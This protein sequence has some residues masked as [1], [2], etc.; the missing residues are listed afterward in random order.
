MQVTKRECPFC[1][2]NEK[3]I[4]LT[5]EAHSFC[6]PNFAYIDDPY[7][8][9]N[10]TR[11]TR[12]PFVKCRNCG[13]MFSE[14]LL[15]DDS[16]NKVYEEIINPATCKDYS[17]SETVFENYRKD[18]DHAMGIFTDKTM[19][20]RALDFGAGWGTWAMIARERIKEVYCYETSPIRKEFIQEAGLN[21]IESESSI[22]NR[23]KFQLINCQEVLEHVPNPKDVLKLL[24]DALS[25]D[26]AIW[27]TVPGCPPD[28][29]Q[30]QAALISKGQNPKEIN[31]W[32]HLN[33][34]TSETLQNMCEAV[35]LV[36]HS[37]F[38]NENQNIETTRCI[39]VKDKM[40]SA[41]LSRSTPLKNV[42]ANPGE[43]TWIQR[44]RQVL[45]F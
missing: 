17:L 38:L 18:F 37:D 32:E 14:D 43:L 8:L 39:F 21:L 27:L 25:D 30:L 16:L 22:L 7:T 41:N 5:M 33:Y 9:L 3:Q 11:S 13:F 20:K 31:P 1:E 4:A 24:R 2:S 15:D 42:S 34:F 29:F 10:I 28:Y 36:P 40:S 35:G 19:V 45:R 12:F 26:G 6:D 23:D 44:L